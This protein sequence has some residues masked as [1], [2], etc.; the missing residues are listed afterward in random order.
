MARRSTTAKASKA[1][2][3]AP[4]SIRAR[5]LQFLL[6]FAAPPATLGALVLLRASVADEQTTLIL[7]AAIA[8]LVGAALLAWV[9]HLSKHRDL[10]IRIMLA[11]TVGL[12]AV[13]TVITLAVGWQAWWARTYITAGEVIA[14]FWSVSRIDALRKDPKGDDDKADNGDD[15]RKELGLEGVKFG[16]AKVIRD[17]EGDIARIEVKA[18][19]KPGT[20]A[21]PL[22]D[23]VPGIESLAGSVLGSGVPIGRSRAI[24]DGP[25][26][27]SL[28]IIT[29]DLLRGL[30][31]YPGPS[32][33]GASITEPLR[34]GVYEDQVPEEV[35][36]AGGQPDAPNPVSTGRMGMTRSGKTAGAHV[37]KL[38]IAARFN[39]AIV[40]LDTVKGAQTAEPLADIFALMIA[41]D[42]K[43]TVRTAVSRMKNVIRARTEL[44][45]RHGF[46]SWCDEASMKL[47]LPFLDF[48]GEEMD[49]ALKDPTVAEDC[50]FIASKGL[51]AGLRLNVSLQRMDANSA[52]SGLRYNLG[53]NYVYGVG[54]DYSAGFLLTDATIAAGAHPENWK[55]KKPGYHYVEGVG[56]PDD[57]A[58][59]PA[60]SYFAENGQMRQLA[61]MLAPGM[62]PLHQVDIDALNGDDGW[63]DQ[64]LATMR[65]QVAAWRVNLDPTSE[66][67]VTDGVVPAQQAVEYLPTSGA[68]YYP[69]S[70]AGYY[71]APTS[72]GGYHQQPPAPR[73]PSYD[74]LVRMPMPM[75]S[76]NAHD[77]HDDDPESIREEVATLH[78]DPD[79]PDGVYDDVDP[80]SRRINPARP[81]EQPAPGAEGM[82][83]GKTQPE[84][85]TKEEAMAALR[86]ALRDMFERPHDPD[87]EDDERITREDEHSVVFGPGAFAARYPFRSRP[88]FSSTFKALVSGEIPTPPG[89]RIERVDAGVYRLTRTLVAVAERT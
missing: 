6:P 9:W 62:M 37:E 42:D 89:Y 71:P 17:A 25:A 10:P 72:G 15:L 75:T 49:D 30:I 48:H 51:S 69:T 4:R 64:M 8:V 7:Y 29:K 24:P 47:G 46:R 36:I 74:P 35:C 31:P 3:T 83:W 82:S 34:I 27:T 85:S 56:I 84:A 77:D 63:Y 67:L 39:A 52:P 54:D 22:Q 12:A 32:R 40:W 61:A 23:A 41:T 87:A 44:L 59:V 28:V 21:K 68:G 65:Q 80:E 43:K 60:K 70:G 14:V 33:L 86:E 76:S 57:R 11:A 5:A 20:T 26:S 18:T 88:W 58:P 1:T 13:G 55:A 50:E 66:G 79:F 73:A 16:G 78:N 81:A 53:L 45:G 38:E 19:N 2:E